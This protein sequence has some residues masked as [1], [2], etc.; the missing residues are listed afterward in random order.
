MELG[1][2]QICRRAGPPCWRAIQAFDV[3]GDVLGDALGDSRM[4]PLFSAEDNLIPQRERIVRRRG[5][6]SISFHERQVIRTGRRNV[7]VRKV[8]RLNVKAQ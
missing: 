8:F 5:I 2:T 7:R 1:A 4:R 3:L 6:C